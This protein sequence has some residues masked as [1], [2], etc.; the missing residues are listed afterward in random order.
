MTPVAVHHNH[1][2]GL[3][4]QRADTLE[5]AFAAHPMRF[6][7]KCPQ[8]PRLPTAAWI[9]PPKQELDPNKTPIPSTLN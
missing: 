9:N 8:P 1:A 4:E 5:A 3:F 6:K 7:G 2:K